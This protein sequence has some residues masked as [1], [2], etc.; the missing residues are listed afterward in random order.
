MNFASSRQ[1]YPSSLRDSPAYLGITT[2]TFEALFSITRT[3]STTYSLTGSMNG[4]TISATDVAD[5]GWDNYNRIFI[6]DGGS[7]IPAS[8]W[9][10]FP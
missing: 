7:T 8:K 1:Y 2:T 10:M 3:A 5:Q 6:R 9:T 4:S